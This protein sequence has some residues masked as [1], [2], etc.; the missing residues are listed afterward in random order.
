[1]F[2]LP[3]KLS[4]LALGNRSEIYQLLFQSAWEALRGKVETE[5]GIQAAAVA[6]LHTWNQHLGHHPHVHMMVPGSGPSLDGKRWIECRQEW[7]RKR[8]KMEP[9]LVDNKELGQEFQRLFLDGLSKLAE[10]GNLE[11]EESGWITDFIDDLR[12]QPWVVFIEGPPKPD[13]PPS[14]MIKYLTRYLT[15]GP[16][17]NSRIVGERDGRIYFMARSKKKGSGQTMT[18]LAAVEFV[19]QWC[20]HILPKEFYEDAAVWSLE[21]LE[22][23]SVP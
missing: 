1:M 3:D 15:G 23:S 20:L 14:Q 21:R 6:V 10:Q 17:S 18:S 11:L 22:A 7:S 13:T 9:F 8:K 16:I 2:T 19:Q 4:S 12:L 5:L